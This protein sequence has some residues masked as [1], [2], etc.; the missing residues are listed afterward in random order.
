M[1]ED[2]NKMTETLTKT[3]YRESLANEFEHSNFRKPNELSK[4]RE[5]L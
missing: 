5:L 3:Q 4:H 2:E 1:F